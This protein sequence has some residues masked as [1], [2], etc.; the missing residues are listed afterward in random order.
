MMGIMDAVG[1]GCEDCEDWKLL[2]FCFRCRRNTTNPTITE[3]AKT[4][5]RMDIP[6]MRDL[7]GPVAVPPTPL[8]DA[9]F[10]VSE[11]DDG[12]GGKTAFV[13]A[14]PDPVVDVDDPAVL[15]TILDGAMLRPTDTAKL[16]VGVCGVALDV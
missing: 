1:L 13:V 15:V 10:A 14:V 9:T 5:A 6:V 2:R 3:A 4:T 11:V 8:D 12:I 7:D 16:D